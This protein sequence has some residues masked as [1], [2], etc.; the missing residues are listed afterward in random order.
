MNWKQENPR[1]RFIDDITWEEAK[2]IAFIAAGKP[3]EFE[4]IGLKA[5]CNGNN[6]PHV[7]LSYRCFDPLLGNGT[8]NYIGIFHNL[9]TYLGREFGSVYC[10]V[11]LFKAFNSMGFDNDK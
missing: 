10:Q 1:N 11:E 8:E 5:D 2:T 7:T 9:N 4:L 6:I 3:D